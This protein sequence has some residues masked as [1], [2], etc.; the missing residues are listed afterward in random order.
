[1][2]QAFYIYVH[3]R[4]DGRP[5]YVG[6]GSGVRAHNM[7]RRNPHHRAI[8]A[9]YGAENIK[10]DLIEMKSDEAAFL[11]EQLLITL[12]SAMGHRP[13]KRMA[14]RALAVSSSRIM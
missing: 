2:G 3:S 12:F 13:T 1:M 9:K 5:F 6:K 7:R 8:I 14:A 4:P 10:V 11:G